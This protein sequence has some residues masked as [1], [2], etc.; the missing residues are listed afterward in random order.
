MI[1]MNEQAVDLIQKVIAR[2]LH[3]RGLSDIHIHAGEPPVVRIFGQLQ[4]ADEAAV[5]ADDLDAFAGHYAPNVRAKICDATHVNENGDKNGQEVS[6][7]V[8]FDC[9][10]KIG[11]RCLRA[12]FYRQ[13]GNYALA[14]RVLPAHQPTPEDIALPATVLSA[15]GDE[16]LVL[17]A[18]ATGSGKSTTIAALIYDILR[19]RRAHLLTIED[20][21]EYPLDGAGS[22][23]SRREIG[24]DAPSFADAV[25]AGLRQDPDI[26]LIGELRDA[27]SAALALTAAETGHL[28]LATL[29]APDCV[30]T[31][32][33]LLGMFAPG[34]RTLSKLQ[35]AQSLRVI[36]A[37][38]L[39]PRSKNANPQTERQH[40][41]GRVAAFETLFANKAV[42]NLIREDKL[43]QI[44]SVMQTSRGEGMLTM[45]GAIE[46]LRTQGLIDGA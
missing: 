18:G 14:L 38:R 28:V 32:S 25:R 39:L 16:G 20:P 45:R 31:I 10:I 1:K 3:K 22:L 2:H 34:E 7:K 19:R 9:R 35:L 42:R 36:I 4:I 44:E 8:S 27:E 12:H 26:I 6:Q 24:R 37:Q 46:N 30:Q 5:S 29:H 13:S 17:V 33:R 41:G 43:F 40:T 21:I 11:D 23:I 15:V